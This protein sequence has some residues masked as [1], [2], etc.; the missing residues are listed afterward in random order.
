[1]SHSPRGSSKSF[2]TV[3]S[4]IWPMTM[5]DS[6]YSHFTDEETSG[7]PPSTGWAR[8]RAGRWEG[9]ATSLEILEGSGFPAVTGS[10]SSFMAKCGLCSLDP[11]LSRVPGG[12]PKWMGAL[13]VHVVS[14]LSLP[15][16]RNIPVPPSRVASRSGNGHLVA[17]SPSPGETVVVSRETH[18]AELGRT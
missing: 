16:L 9:V 6:Y 14:C 3:I 7:I 11:R 4:F 18:V 5:Q 13:R 15:R 1:M 10:C 17:P 8:A 2:I 12:W